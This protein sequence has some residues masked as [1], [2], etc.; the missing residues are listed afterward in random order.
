M[1]P[2]T[3]GRYRWRTRLRRMLPWALAERVPKGARDCSNHEWYNADGVVDR[4]YHCDA[5]QRP[6]APERRLE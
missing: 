1:A 4:C 2:L 5:G 3:P 6:H